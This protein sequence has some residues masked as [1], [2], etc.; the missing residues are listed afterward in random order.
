MFLHTNV[1]KEERAGTQHGARDSRLKTD[2][3]RRHFNTEGVDRR[4]FGPGVRLDALF[5][6]PSDVSKKI[7]QPKRPLIVVLVF[8]RPFS[9]RAVL[10]R[11]SSK[12]LPLHSFP[13][14]RDSQYAKV[15]LI[16]FP[17]PKALR[18][19]DFSC[20]NAFDIF[21][22][23]QYSS[24]E[25]FNVVFNA[26]PA[27]LSLSLSFYPLPTLLSSDSIGFARSENG[28]QKAFRRWCL[29]R[30][31]LLQHNRFYEITMHVGVSYAVSSIE[32]LVD[33][34]VIVAHNATGLSCCSSL[35]S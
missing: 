26:T 13:A 19:I 21:V 23:T 29:N 10:K 32:L 16:S 35:S 5:T 27:S 14:E 9:F 18:F 2:C 20:A 15:F 1:Q 22:A 28:W 25:R 30:E 7:F 11:A 34:Y 31:L 8:Y 12:E 17:R 6:H 24:D 3:S 4:T 33:F